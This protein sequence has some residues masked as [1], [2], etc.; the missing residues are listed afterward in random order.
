MVRARLSENRST[1]PTFR[2]GDLLV[3]NLLPASVALHQVSFVVQADGRFES[4]ERVTGCRS[5]NKN[6]IYHKECGVIRSTELENIRSNIQALALAAEPG[7]RC[8]MEQSP[9]PFEHESADRR[10]L[11]YAFGAEGRTLSTWTLNWFK[12]NHQESECVAL[13]D[14]IWQRLLGLLVMRYFTFVPDFTAP[15]QSMA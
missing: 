3:A 14:E 8:L 9:D 2:Q 1:S 12:S 4:S 5:Q 15:V 11:G 13:F 10:S 6:S 7:L